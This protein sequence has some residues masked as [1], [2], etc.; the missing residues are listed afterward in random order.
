MVK[1]DILRVMEG[2]TFLAPQ[3]GVESCEPKGHAELEYKG[4]RVTAEMG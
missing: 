2:V 4:N 3:R 1:V